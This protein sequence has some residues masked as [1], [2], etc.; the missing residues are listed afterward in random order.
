M[1]S[2]V[3]ATIYRALGAKPAC[4]VRDQPDQLDREVVISPLLDGRTTA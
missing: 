2:D 3:G 1:P 4:E